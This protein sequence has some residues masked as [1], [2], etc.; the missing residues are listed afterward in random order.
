M[1][2]NDVNKYG[3]QATDTLSVL[4]TLFENDVNKYGTHAPHAPDQLGV[5]V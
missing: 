3:T 1:F 2:E 5:I 4:T